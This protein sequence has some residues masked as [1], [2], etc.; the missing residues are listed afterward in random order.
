MGLMRW[1]AVAVSPSRALFVGREAERARLLAAY[2]AAAAG[3]GAL[4]LVVGEPG[5]GKT[6]LCAWL[7]AEVRERGGLVLTGHSY[8]EGSLSLPYLPFVEALRAYIEDRGREQLRR[9]LG[10]S[11]TEIARIVPEVR[12]LLGVEPGPSTDP[13]TDRYRLFQAVLSTLRMIT[14]TRPLLLV[15]EDLH[16]ADRGTLDLLLHLARNLNG[17][18]LLIVA[19]YRDVEVDRRHPLSATLAALRRATA[20]E[21]VRLGGL[22]P[23]ETDALTRATAGTEVEAGI[24]RLVHDQTEGNPLFVQETA[25][26]LVE[27]GRLDT[28]SG[29]ARES[30]VLSGVPEGVRDVIGRRLSRLS[31]VCNRMLTVAA[32]IGRDFTLRTVLT[33]AGEGELVVVEALETAVEAGVLEEQ[34]RRGGVHYRFAHA[35]FRQTLYEEVRAAR[36]IRLHQQ[37]AQALEAEYAASLPEHAAQLADHFAHSSDPDDLAKAVSYGEVAA[38]RA[39][40]VYAHGE[41]ARLLEQTLDVQDVLDPANRARICDLSIVLVEALLDA[42]QAVRVVEEV[43]PRAFELAEA[44]DEADRIAQVCA[45]ACRG[46]NLI[47]HRAAW[48]SPAGRLWAERLDRAAPPDTV[49]RVRADLALGYLH[50]HSGRRAEAIRFVTRALDLARRLD[51]NGVLWECVEAWLSVAEAPQHAATRLAVARELLTYPRAGVALPWVESGLLWAA[52]GLL[53]WGLWDEAFALIGEAQSL[54]ER[55]EQLNLKLHGMSFPALLDTL[56]GRLEE[57]AAA[58][59]RIMRRG[60]ELGIADYARWP[61]FVGSASALILLGRTSELLRY[62]DRPSVHALAHAEQG[63]HDRAVALL[64]EHVVGRPLF[65]SAEDVTTVHE[66]MQYLQAA[67][68]VQ[69]HRAAAMLLARFAGSEFVMPGIKCMTSIARHLGAAAAM[70]GRGDDAQGW[71]AKALTDMEAM[72]FRPEI[73]LVRL[74]TAELLAGHFP[75]EAGVAREHLALAIPEFET[76]GMQSALERA[77]QLQ[78]RLTTPADLNL[79]APAPSRPPLEAVDSPAMDMADALPVEAAPASRVLAT[80]LFT[81]IVDSTPRTLALGD[82]AWRELK[83]RHHA[84]VRAELR[85]FGGREVDTAGDAFFAVFDAPARALRCATAIIQAVQSLGLEVRAGLHFGEVEADDTGVAGIAVVIGAR[86]AARA[87]AREVLV[88]Q[89]VRDLVAGSGLTFTERGTSVLK[90]VPGEWPLFALEIGAAP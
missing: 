64:D 27:E 59:E 54:E 21:R 7:A 77:Q 28:G 42:G 89:V 63:E 32:V 40:E 47:G 11:A 4:A 71:Y 38:R 61:A 6:T 58:G 39:A 72:R 76:M 85:R 51:H 13:E 48:T 90:G 75:D 20:V 29:A 49:V 55:G 15:L 1:P 46:L 35:L 60:Q 8:E 41:A 70:L 10:P 57:A 12:D 67:L 16:D 68:L 82:A 78:R 25:R 37:V 65:G 9:E 56:D 45:Q 88:T 5:I 79:V 81:D 87:T 74:Q 80:L 52:H 24:A 22:S 26:W 62:E 34:E 31:D 14:A 33:V 36:R 19:T 2:E 66:D 43:A 30:A 3:D 84:A 18:P 86:V 23:E 44:L 83:A 50:S 53:T 73:A 69:H 17:L